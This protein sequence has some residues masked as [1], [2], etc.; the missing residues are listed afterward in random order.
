MKKY[1]VLSFEHVHVNNNTISKPSVS[2]IFS[3]L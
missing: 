3:A 2:D 1:C